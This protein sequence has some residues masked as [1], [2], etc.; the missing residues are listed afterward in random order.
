MKIPKHILLCILALT[1]YPLFANSDSLSP[2]EDL[3]PEKEF[4]LFQSDEILNIIL[5]CTD[6]K[7]V[8]RDNGKEP[9]E[10]EALLSVIDKN[11]EP[12]D[13]QVKIQTRG[14]FRKKS[15]NCG[16][17]PLRVNFDKDQVENTLFENQNKL[18][19]VT[20]C[21]NFPSDFDQHVIKEYLVYKMYNRMTDNS[22]RVRLARIN[23]VDAKGWKQPLERYAF[24]IEDTRDVAERTSHTH[25]KANSIPQEYTDEYHE[26]LMS[27]FQF[28]VG[29]TD[30][31]I[32]QRHN[33]KLL[34][35]TPE[36][37]PIPVPYDFDWTGFVNPPYAK[38]SDILNIK[39]VEERLYRGYERSNGLFLKV[40]NELRSNQ[41]AFYTL[42]TESPLD[43]KNKKNCRQ[44]LDSFFTSI[45]DPGFIQREIILQSR[46]S[47]DAYYGK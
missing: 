35:E 19:L 9:E 45:S 39:S 40:I 11:G 28:M 3:I 42:I 34:Y 37:N 26:T 1:V 10:H 44:Y 2:K 16:F 41:E 14:D 20:H 8:L 22:F 27:M 13:F 31:S 32:K 43:E 23:Y 6:L 38:P 36:D 12:S 24:F 7:L 21:R 17:P 29:N 46:K 33:I 25:V 5:Y 18:K 4:P 30:W 15:G 47:P